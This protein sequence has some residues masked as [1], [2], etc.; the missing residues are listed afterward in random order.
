[1]LPNGRLLLTAC[2]GEPSDPVLQ[3]N[4]ADV[5]PPYPW[6]GNGSRSD[7]PFPGPS[8]SRTLFQ[9]TRAPSP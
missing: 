1:M 5:N 9:A 6:L 3:G 8:W 4:F 2:I 7:G